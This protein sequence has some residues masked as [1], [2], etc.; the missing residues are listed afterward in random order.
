VPPSNNLAPGQTL[1]QDEVPSSSKGTPRVRRSL[2]FNRSHDT[3][4]NEIQNESRMEEQQT[5]PNL[6]RQDEVKHLQSSMAQS[7]SRDNYSGRPK[8]VVRVVSPDLGEQD[9]LPNT[10]SP[11]RHISFSQ[12]SSPS[13]HVS[14]APPNSRRS[15]SPV[16]A[17]NQVRTLQYLT[18]ELREVVGRSGEC[19]KY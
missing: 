10:R 5:V 17:E 2:D 15:F 8:K 12:S 11:T 3:L 6:N 13:E 1:P 9:R 18:R 4:K 16:A 7:R 14:S 19:I